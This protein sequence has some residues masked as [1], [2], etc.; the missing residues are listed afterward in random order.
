MSRYT[1]DGTRLA[2]PQA[3]LLIGRLEVLGHHRKSREDDLVFAKRV[4]GVTNLIVED[5]D[6][7]GS[8]KRLWTDPPIPPRAPQPNPS[9]EP[10]DTEGS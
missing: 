4:A 10:G 1:F 6:T 5:V 9:A 8:R 2:H 3:T 7:I